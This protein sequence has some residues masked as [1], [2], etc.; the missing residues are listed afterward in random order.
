MSL[1]PKSHNSLVEAS[2][3]KRRASGPSSDNNDGFTSHDL[4]AAVTDRSASV[5]SPIS[6][7]EVLSAYTAGND[8]VNTSMSSSSG[9][10]V[11]NTSTLTKETSKTTIRAGA[12]K[13]APILV[14]SAGTLVPTPLVQTRG[15][16]PST[17]QQQQHVITTTMP[18][19]QRVPSGAIMEPV[20]T[21]IAA[22]SGGQPVQLTAQPLAV[23]EN[24]KSYKSYIIVIICLVIVGAIGYAGYWILGRIV[25][26]FLDL[27]QRIHDYYFNHNHG[28]TI[29]ERMKKALGF[30]QD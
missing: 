22:S 3:E 17:H 29:G 28:D 7:I 26:W 23:E 18:P 14:A 20:K 1:Q 2:D 24:S 11:L 27:F 12:P 19:R 5:V 15:S 10:T 21:L 25:A 16:Q 9:A 13:P 4:V 30:K 6:S 8:P